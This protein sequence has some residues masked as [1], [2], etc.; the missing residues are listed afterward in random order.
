MSYPSANEPPTVPMGEQVEAAGAVVAG[1]PLTH[2]S[3]DADLSALLSLGL[4]LSDVQ[5]LWAQNKE[6]AMADV[7]DAGARLL[8]SHDTSVKRQVPAMPLPTGSLPVP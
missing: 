6:V 3:L 2:T 1:S 4:Q 8:G 5:N 7:F